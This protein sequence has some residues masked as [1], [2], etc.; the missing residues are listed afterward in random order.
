MASKA[1]LALKAPL[2]APG[3]R[4][5]RPDETVLRLLLWRLLPMR[6]AITKAWFG[7]DGTYFR[8]NLEP[9]GAERDCGQDGRP[10]KHPP[11]TPSGYYHD[12]YFTSGLETLAMMLDYVD[13]TGDAAFRDGV[14]VP[15]ARQV[16]LFFDQHYARGADGKLRIDPG[17]VLETWWLAVNPAPDVAGLRQHEREVIY[18]MGLQA[19]GCRL[20]DW[21][22]IRPYSPSYSG[23]LRK[24]GVR[25]DCRE[26]YDILVKFFA[27]IAVFDKDYDE[28][29]PFPSP[30]MPL[31][32]LSAS[33]HTW[34]TTTPPAAITRAS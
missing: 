26:A 2:A 20:A 13:F 14:A 28:L 25:P 31:W 15:F 4:R 17:Q 6:Q 18:S 11:G 16:L 7:H 12:H 5:F 32:I 23:F 27:P 8:E 9:T 34:A 33:I 19:R 24:E 10:P 29:G 3:Q 22:D 1:T 30:P 21:F